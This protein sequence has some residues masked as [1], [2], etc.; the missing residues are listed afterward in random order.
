MEKLETETVIEYLE[1]VENQ[2]NYH[3]SNLKD[4]FKEM[5]EKDI[6]I[7]NNCGC[8]VYKDIEHKCEE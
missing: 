5:K 3:S 2:F 8:S 4:I 1:R 7:C 6:K